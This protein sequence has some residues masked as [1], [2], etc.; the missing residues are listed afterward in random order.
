MPQEG[1]TEIY[2]AEAPYSFNVGTNYGVVNSS[3]RVQVVSQ[4]PQEV[5][6]HPDLVLLPEGRNQHFVGRE[7]ELA[8]LQAALCGEGGP[9][10]AVVHGGIGAGK[11]AL[12]LEYARRHRD[13]H[14]PV[15]HLVADSPENVT[16]GLAALADRLHPS[17]RHGGASPEARADWAGAWLQCHSGWLLIL[18]EVPGPAAVGRLLGSLGDRGAVLLTTRLATGWGRHATGVAL[19][20]LP[21]AAAVRLLH[22]RTGLDPD[23]PGLRELAARLGHL[24]LALEQAGAYLEETGAG[25]PDYLALLRESPGEALGTAAYGTASARTLARVWHHSVAAVHGSNPHAVHLLRVLAWLAPHG[26][27]RGLLDRLRAETSRSP[28]SYA[29]RPARRLLWRT[30][31]IRPRRAGTGRPIPAPE[32]ARALAV[33]RAYSLVRVEGDTL[34]VHPLVQTV[35]RT[36]DPADPHRRPRAVRAAWAEAQELLLDAALDGR[37]TTRNPPHGQDVVPHLEAFLAATPPSGEDL[38]TAALCLTT[39]ARLNTSGRPASD[40]HA[41]RYAERALRALRK[42]LLAGVAHPA[43]RGARVH[44]ARALWRSGAFDEALVLLEGP[45]LRVGRGVAM[46]GGR[47]LLLAQ[48]YLS[49]ER[50]Q[51]ALPL[52]EAEYD[53]LRGLPGGTHPRTLIVRGLLAAA[54]MGAGDLDRGLALFEENDWI[55]GARGG[56]T[57]ETLDT[58]QALAHAYVRV[59]ETA[60]AIHLYERTL[61]RA[62]EELGQRH[63]ATL[64]TRAALAV[65]HA[66]AGHA[67]TATGL[68]EETIAQAPGAYDPDSTFLMFCREWLATL[69]LRGGD[70][71]R[72]T[73]LH[74]ANVAASERAFGPRHRDVQLVRH[75]FA[76]DL[77]DAGHPRQAVPL[78]EEALEGLAVAVGPA[79]RSAVRTRYQLGRALRLAEQADRAV[80]LQEEALGQAQATLPVDDPLALAIR[81]ECG[82]TYRDE[83]DLERAAHVLE[84]V[85]QDSGAYFGDRSEHRLEALEALE[86]LRRTRNTPGQRRS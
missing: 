12:A 8:L 25:L 49:L 72:A 30:G 44:L 82:Y 38:G 24:P 33:L 2:R 69:A 71:K 1:R 74:E 26:I 17:L 77:L 46:L 54:H 73:G 48:C 51:E 66:A 20:V 80:A 70:T 81:L 53:F 76:V 23:A 34:A 6:A 85:A 58:Q 16:T 37:L 9:A 67:P 13:A 27:P 32:A 64:R 84:R 4:P 14:H 35:A 5:T 11:S 45:S 22:R 28:A 10:L 68:F 60:R 52:L 55:A 18:D 42:R 47:R 43:Y 29:V 41:V 83:G 78:L 61:R 21:E 31:W 57:P 3:P 19:D 75:N 62:T 50:F 7:A 63:P 65:A 79:H 40:P 56:T 86:E 15:V 36:A 39:A 59:G